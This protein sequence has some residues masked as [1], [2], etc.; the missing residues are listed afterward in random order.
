[1]LPVGM[2]RNLNA[3]WEQP[4]SIGRAKYVNAGLLTATDIKASYHSRG[5]VRFLD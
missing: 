1:M 5:E 4:G 3:R 2:R